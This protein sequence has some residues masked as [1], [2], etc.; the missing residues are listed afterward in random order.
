MDTTSERL[1][2]ARMARREEWQRVVAEQ[3]ASGKKIAVFCLERGLPAWKFHY[4]R[5]ALVSRNAAGNAVGFVQV[6][7]PTA[8]ASGAQVWVE[9]GDCRI[10]VAP[11]FDERT[12]RRVVTT[13][14]S[15]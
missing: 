12:L 2:D 15:A 6:K 10:C 4:W 1:I 13:L 8:R 14:A 11:G 5:K 7:V 9:T 3:A